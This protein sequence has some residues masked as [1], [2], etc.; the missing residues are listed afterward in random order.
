M[1]LVFAL[2]LSTQATGQ[3]AADTP[4]PIGQLQGELAHLWDADTAARRPVESQIVYSESNKAGYP[5]YKIEGVYVNGVE[6]E[7]GTDRIFFYYSRPKKPAGKLPVFIEL[8]G[9]AKDETAN[10]WMASVLKC[11]VV[12]VEYRCFEASLRS[13]WAGYPRPGRAMPT[14]YDMSSLRSNFLYRMVAGT[15]RVIDYLSTRPEVDAANIGCGGGSLG[16]YLTLLLAGVDPR[17]RFGVDELGAGWKSD[18]Q[19]I[20]SNLGLPDEYKA[21]WSKAF[22]AYSYAP[23]TKARIYVNLSANDATFW[24]GDGLDNYAALTGEKRL[25]LS[26]NDDHSWSSFGQDHYLPLFTWV[27]Y[28]IGAEKD[29]PEITAVRTQGNRYFMTVKDSVPIKQ[30]SLYWS[31]G[32]KL[33]WPA[34]YWKEIPATLDDGSWQAE[35]PEQYSKL[36]KYV[37]MNVVDAGARRASSVPVFTPGSDPREAAG[38]LWEDGQL[39]DARH[40]ASAWRPVGGG[41]A[42]RGAM[43]SHVA[44]SPPHTLS[45]GPEKGGRHFTL[46]TNSIIL[47]AGHAKAH[48]GLELSVDGN[49]RPGELLIGLLRN[50]GSAKTEEELLHTL[51]YGPTRSAYRI[52]W[53]EFIDVKNPGR[54]PLGFDGLRIDGAR[55][56]GS[57][58]TLGDMTLF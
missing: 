56:D 27:P 13:K 2:L 46:V 55:D 38:P 41:S 57:A 54:S 22:N 34:R 44:F 33:G 39:W 12:H 6:D 28:C 45:V 49:G 31:P 20:F 19:S 52:P 25:G 21:V 9:G 42:R 1:I 36:A 53:S 48:R 10:V 17:I 7:T 18:S 14:V 29:Y 5:D 58:V 32:E 50:T 47:A 8:T 37:F 3:A 24:L 26:P 35:I 16:G 4:P 23:G 40:G 15:R 11:A 43:K 51:R 30:A